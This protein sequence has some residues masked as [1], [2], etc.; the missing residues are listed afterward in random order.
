MPHQPAPRSNNNRSNNRQTGQVHEFGIIRRVASNGVSVNPYV[1]PT[2]S[3]AHLLLEDDEEEVPNVRR[4]NVNSSNRRSMQA[5]YLLVRAECGYAECI[6]AS[7]VAAGKNK[8]WVGVPVLWQQAYDLIN[9]TLEDTSDWW[10]ILLSASD[11][12]PVPED[13]Q[14]G[15]SHT[16]LVELLDSLRIVEESTE[17]E[18]QAALRLLDK[19]L[20][21][22]QEKLNPL[23]EGRRAAMTAMG[24]DRW[25]NNPRPK[26]DYAER[27]RLLAVE[28]TQLLAALQVLQELQLQ[29]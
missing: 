7:A 2:N 8:D 16:L 4:S 24:E 17:R 29:M 25:N 28:E 23:Q 27:M 21:K 10:A 9:R 14:D 1:P 6:R 26:M 20:K 19:N 13:L 5:R 15:H 22:V 18:R 12:V 11:Q 3:F